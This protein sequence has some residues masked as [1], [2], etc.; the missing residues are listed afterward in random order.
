MK[1]NKELPTADRWAFPE[2]QCPFCGEIQQDGHDEKEWTCIKCG[3][4]YYLAPID[5]EY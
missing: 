4:D 1:E 2:H 5:G 3:E